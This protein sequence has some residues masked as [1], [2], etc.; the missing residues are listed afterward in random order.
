MSAYT[1]MY[2]EMPFSHHIKFRE[3]HF[4]SVFTV[5]SSV[6]AHF[7]KKLGSVITNASSVATS[8]V[9]YSETG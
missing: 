8:I 1:V 6:P 4:T 3:L 2:E 7:Q 5:M 9:S